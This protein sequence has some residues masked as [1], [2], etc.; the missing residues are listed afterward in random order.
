MERFES[1]YERFSF[2][3]NFD[4]FCKSFAPDFHNFHYLLTLNHTSNESTLICDSGET[5]GND[6]NLP[7]E[8]Y[9]KNDTEFPEK[10]DLQENLNEESNEAAIL[11]DRLKGNF[12]IKI[13]VYLSKRKL[14]KIS[15]SK[16]SLFKFIP[17]SNTIDIAKL[18][19]KLETVGRMLQ[20]KW[21]FRNDEKQFNP[22]KFKA[23]S[24]F[25]PRNKNTAIQIYLGSLEEKLMSIEIPKDK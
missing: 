7:N 15:E 1:H 13:F 21:F 11:N 24:S 6:L 22:Y 2:K 20:L 18:K 14:S 10:S 17:T 16:I 8:V 23:K 9:A 3:Y 12:V 19:T 5:L 4:N 25:N